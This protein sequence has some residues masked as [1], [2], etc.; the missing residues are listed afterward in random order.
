MGKMFSR[1]RMYFF[2]FF[3]KE[4]R[5]RQADNLM[6]HDALIKMSVWLPLIL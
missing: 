6:V 3:S 1:P 2:F 5:G 4:D